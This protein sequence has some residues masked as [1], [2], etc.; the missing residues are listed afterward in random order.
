MAGEPY[1]VRLRVAGKADTLKQASI[2]PREVEG[3]YT[4]GPAV[5]GGVTTSTKETIAMLAMLVPREL[6]AYQIH[7][8]VS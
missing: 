7:F 2:I 5:G 1:E 6:V 3:L 8:E 4:N